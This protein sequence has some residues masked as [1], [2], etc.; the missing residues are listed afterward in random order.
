MSH[1]IDV[2][3]SLAAAVAKHAPSVVRV[4]A[5]RGSAA[6]GIVWSEGV[7]LTAS[8][9]LEWDEGLEVGLPDG[10]SV[11]AALAGRDPGTDLAALRLESGGSDPVPWEEPPLK[12]G[13]LVLG[14]SR[15]GHSA[16]ARLGVVSALADSWRAPSGAPLERYI[17][18]DIAP[19]PGF[20]GSLLVDAGGRAIGMNSAG[21]LRKTS[22]ALD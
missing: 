15:P 16:R 14:V 11:K 8:Q 19:H 22:L 17:E 13:Q 20:S 7:V 10:R 12:L 6:S 4:E 1:A 3:E 9:A 2:S 18:S 5:R 21:L